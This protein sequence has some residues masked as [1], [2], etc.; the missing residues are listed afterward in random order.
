MFT[1]LGKSSSDD[2]YRQD[3]VGEENRV[4]FYGLLNEANIIE[5]VK[6][7]KIRAVFKVKRPRDCY[8]TA[9]VLN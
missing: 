1:Y 4:H 7:D 2:C 9:W 8:M 3:I 6:A 5:D